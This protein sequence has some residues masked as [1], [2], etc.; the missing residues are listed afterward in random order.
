M[1]HYPYLIIGAGITGAAAIRGIRKQDPTGRIGIITDEPHPPYK[2]PFL[3]KALWKGISYDK[4]WIKI[5]MQHIDLHQSTSIIRI[6][7]QNKQVVDDLGTV[8]GYDNLLLATGGVARHLPWDVDGVIYFRELDDYLQLKSRAEAGQHFAVIGGGF[9]GSEIAAAL[10]INGNKVTMIYPEA[11]IGARIYP[12]ALAHFLNRYYQEKG[13]NM[14]AGQTVDAITQHS[15]G[16]TLNTQAGETLDVDGV[17]V[18]IGIQINSGLAEAAGLKVDNGILVDDFLHTSDPAIYAAGDA[19][20]FFNPALGNRMR[21]E[22]EDNANVMGETAGRNMAGDAVPYDHLPFFY[23]DL[24]DLGYEAVGE[25]DAGM[26]LVED[27]QEPFRKGVIYYLKEKRVRG[28][29]LWNTWGHMETARA[30]IAEAGPF[31]SQQL[32]GRIR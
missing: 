6:D 28:V 1:L 16:Y 2:R 30:L 14:L 27:W 25:L 24:F 7:R 32:K 11:A 31:S 18:G 23:T 15:D 17:V 12:E 10:T 9:I 29:L 4:V 26:E 20:N 13:I 8:Y 19:A 5:D 22:H 21:V 3:S